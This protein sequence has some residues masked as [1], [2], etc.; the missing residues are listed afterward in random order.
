M[1]KDAARVTVASAEALRDWLAAHHAQAEP[2]WLVTWKAHVTEKYVGRED[3]LDALVAFG[4]VDGRRMKLDDDRTMQL[5][6]PR[7]QQ[8]WAD[9]YKTRAARLEAEGR[10]AAPGRASV[11]AGKA[12]GLWDF[13]ADVD[14]LIVPEDLG[15]ALAA[16]PP[17]A[18]HF[19]AFAPSA[20]RN[21]LRWVKIAKTAPTRAKRIAE[22]AR[23]A[24]ENRKPPQM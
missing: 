14:A 16:L 21:I 8:A 19:D 17:A 15:Q 13:Y 5:I 23:L 24:A 22:V 2:V 20:K 1:S 12:S 7:K 18:M 10:M 4:W 9:S 6:A 11:A 3:V